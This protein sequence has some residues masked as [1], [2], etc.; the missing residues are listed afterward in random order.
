MKVEKNKTLSTSS[1]SLKVF[2][3]KFG[4]KGDSLTFSHLVYINN[5]NLTLE[6]ESETGILNRA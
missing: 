1:T 2:L 6:F 5:I 3:F 4:Q